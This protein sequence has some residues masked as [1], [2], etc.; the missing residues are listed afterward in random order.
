MCII[1]ALLHSLYQY[2]L[3]LPNVEWYLHRIAQHRVN[4]E[5]NLFGAV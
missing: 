2:Q 1:L 3:G 4:N 5:H